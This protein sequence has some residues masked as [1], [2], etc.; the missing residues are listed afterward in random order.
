MQP[1]NWIALAGIVA[2]TAISI[3]VLLINR[4]REK[5]QQERDDRL[6]KDQQE[7]EDKLR[8]EQQE[9]ETEEEMRRR[10]YSPHIEFE[11]ECNFY[12][13]EIDC[14]I[15][16]FQIIVH[17]K[18]IIQQKF[19]DIRLRVRGI[20]SEQPI[21]FWPGNEPRLNFPTK[22]VDNT[23]ILP[24]DFNFFFVEPGIEQTF[25]FVTK[26][27]LSVKYILAHAEFEY[28]KFTPHTTERTFIVKAGG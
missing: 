24:K 15:A 14:F 26:I 3:V 13:P 12:G 9:R 10:T 25:T 22:I 20:D 4:R 21:S 5:Q 23:S 16:E 8:K 28:D 7:R 1:E 18:G 11:I 6:R 19:R 17:N 2:T 27:P